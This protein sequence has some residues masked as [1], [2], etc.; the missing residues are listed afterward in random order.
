MRPTDP[1]FWHLDGP[2]GW[3]TLRSRGVAEGREGLQLEADPA[4]P[5]ALDA[6]DG[7]LGGLV[8]PR[9]MAV[10]EQGV[11][12]L[13]S[14]PR[15][16]VL[17]YLPAGRTR[18]AELDCRPG[19]GPS[20][21]TAPGRFCPLPTVGGHGCEARRFHYP[22][23]LAVAGRDLVVADLGNRRVQLF[24]L[25]TLA[26]LAVWGPLD[27]G[28]NPLPAGDDKAWRPVDVASR[29]TTMF[30]LDGR[31]GRV[32]RRDRG[33]G[34][35]R[36]A[37]SKPSAANRWSRIAFDRVGRFY[38]LDRVS[39]ELDVYEAEG[40]SCKS[41]P[42][43]G[44]V[45]DRFDP[46]PIRLD[47]R[48][49]FCLPGDLQRPCDRRAPAGPPPEAPLALCSQADPTRAGDPAGQLFDRNGGAALVEEGERPGTPA[50]RKAGT[51][52]AGPLDSE[53]YRCQWDR[54]EFSLRVL[55]PGSRVR[56]RTYAD[57]L[58]M[59]P[60]SLPGRTD[61][62][63]TGY[64]LTGP[65]QPP[66]GDV[67]V[68][69]EEDF[70]IQGQQGRYLWILV[71]LESDGTATPALTEIRVRY[72]R[73]SYLQYLPTEYSAEEESRQFLES[74]L[75]IIQAD[76]DRIEETLAA[77]PA[78]FDPKAVP[79]V[80]KGKPLEWLA[81]WLALR[82]EAS[83]TPEQQR[84]LLAA[85]P[86][87]YQRRGTLDGVRE[88]VRVYLENVAG[89]AEGQQAAF[90]QFVEGFRERQHL[91]VS[92]RR[93]A[94]LGEGAPL[95]SR[96]MVGRLQADVFAREGEVRLVST[97]DPDR[98]VFHHYAHQFRVYVPA[99][100]VRTAKQEQAIRRAIDTEKP[101]HTG[102][103]LCLVE[104]RFRVGVQ[105]TVGLD[106]I[107]GGYPR[108]Q[109]ACRHDTSAASSLP[110]RNRLGYDTL[111]VC[112]GRPRGGRL[113]PAMRAGI[114]SV[115]A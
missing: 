89:L 79:A 30:V 1:T 20:T 78:Y 37:V 5:L 15:G 27:G 34:E 40:G 42:D 94:E 8:L 21:E 45:R 103:D 19:P 22:S 29:G 95:W 105:S 56:V 102:Y 59:S 54:V 97:G 26:L 61:P 63:W 87:I 75:A 53:V 110:P 76:L 90:P 93:G 36:L 88:F 39:R 70:L 17:R 46:P 111:L 64:S 85:A 10:D 43:A 12:F 60:R 66:P 107:I 74:F 4:G 33:D 96:S 104:P 51:W 48:G 83:W 55:P 98:D 91:L 47:H 31:Y 112:G 7:S 67:A 16:T 92:L 106:T 18:E 99:A 23:N 109:L 77:M 71:D 50:Y 101:A 44:S 24:D 68:P 25:T 69:R 86:S 57:E 49:R 80:P 81:G 3:R 11:V 58:P 13:L 41:V 84:R 72:P 9:R 62:L 35:L 52:L 6:P 14:L 28:G 114:D 2:T 82:M 32:Y 113:G 115:L 73:E 65:S 100:W 38:L 108:A